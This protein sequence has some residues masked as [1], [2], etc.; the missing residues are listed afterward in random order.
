MVLI[1]ASVGLSVFDKP[2]REGACLGEYIQMGPGT[3]LIYLEMN[4]SLSEN[5]GEGRE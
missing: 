5:T 3:M 4:C 1:T 2:R